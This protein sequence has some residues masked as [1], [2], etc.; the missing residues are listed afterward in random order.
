[1]VMNRTD[2]VTPRPGKNESQATLRDP[3]RNLV[4]RPLFLTRASICKNA[5]P[6]RPTIVDPMAPDAVMTGTP[7]S[8]IADESFESEGRLKG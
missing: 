6:K 7:R 8:W 4:A 5:A 2:N 1:M 3:R